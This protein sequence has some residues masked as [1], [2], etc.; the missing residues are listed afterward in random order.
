MANVTQTWVSVSEG[1]AIAGVSVGSMSRAAK[2]W[3]KKPVGRRRLIQR[4]MVEEYADMRRHKARGVPG[5]TAAA[6]AERVGVNERTA[7]RYRSEGLIDGYSEATADAVRAD[8]MPLENGDGDGDGALGDIETGGQAGPLGSLSGP[9]ELIEAKA[10]KVPKAETARLKEFWQMVGY[11]TRALREAGKLYEAKEVEQWAAKLGQLVKARIQELPRSVAEAVADKPVHE[12]R[13]I[14]G[15]WADNATAE[16]SRALTEFA[17]DRAAVG[18]AAEAAAAAAASP[19]SAEAD[20]SPASA[21]ADADADAA[22]DDAKPDDDTDA[23]E[24]D[25]TEPD[26]LDRVRRRS[27]H[28]FRNIPEVHVPEV[29]T[30]QGRWADNDAET[31]APDE[32]DTHA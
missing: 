15:R 18:G 26:E 30:I 19:A 22:A 14:L 21:E 16:L 6:W 20:A 29:R 2:S 27:A 8:R 3:P 23:A 9:L 10:R 1:A 12:V 11:R 28:Q 17:E 25:A 32:D 4:A 7:R 24:A 13:T 5:M 31:G